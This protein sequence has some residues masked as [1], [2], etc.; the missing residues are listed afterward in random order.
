M[1]L[2]FARNRATPRPFLESPTPL[3][4]DL[5]ELV[6]P[7]VRWVDAYLH[8]TRSPGCIGDVAAATLTRR[9]L[10]RFVDQHPR[11]QQVENPHQGHSH[12]Y[13]FWIRLRKPLDLEIAGSISLRIG[14]DE[15][16]RCYLG[17]I[18]YGVFP[19]LR[20][21]RIAERATLLLLP[22]AASH[23]L[24]ELWVTAN[25][26][27]LASRKT[28]ERLGGELVD[29]VNLPNAHPLY[30]RGERRKCRY[31]IDLQPKTPSS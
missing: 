1:R 4:D 7:S 11:G 3:T 10:L 12:G 21:Q 28:C 29:I 9:D 19:P 23:G 16:L 25:P 14:D 5:I 17:H 24:K 26:D 30:L 18:G 22:L 31:R 27:N 13:T 15:N 6:E 8:T 2:W 20:G